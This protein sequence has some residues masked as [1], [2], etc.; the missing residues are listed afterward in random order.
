[1]KLADICIDSIKIHSKIKKDIKHF[2]FLEK[3]NSNDIEIL[4][5]AKKIYI[6]TNKIITAFDVFYKYFNNDVTIITHNSDRPV[7]KKHIKYINLPKIKKWFAQNTLIQHKKLYTLPIGIA[8]PQW[9][10][11]NIELLKQIK[12]IDKTKENLLF[13]NFELG[14]GKKN[15]IRKPILDTLKRNDFETKFNRVDQK[16]YWLMLASSKFSISPEG[17]GIDCHRI[18]ECIF[19][20]TIPIVYRHI[21]FKQFE[22]L[23]ILFIDNWNIIT[24]EFLEE[25][26]IKF[27]QK[28]FN[29]DKIYTEYWKNKINK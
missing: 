24:R 22:E 15:S 5:G 4:K 10:H 13:T 17:G 28:T 25:Q 2:I 6:V 8:N 14:T 20:K 1:M 29:I 19:L 7:D 23:P 9:K 12:T 18:W 3:Y 27:S 26:W 21:A 11:G 16:K